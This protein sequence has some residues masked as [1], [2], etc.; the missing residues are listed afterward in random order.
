MNN[1]TRNSVKEQNIAI[2]TEMRLL[3]KVN[4]TKEENMAFAEMRKRGESLPEGVYQHFDYVSNEYIDS[5]YRIDERGAEEA[6][7][8]RYVQ[9]NILRN[10][11]TIKNILIFFA[12]LVVIS[13]IAAIIIIATTKSGQ[14]YL[15]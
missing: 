15:Y 5:F 1:Q 6:D 12:V 4:C 10:L 9:L 3:N 7:R 13:I 8:D 14:R 11:K 2:E